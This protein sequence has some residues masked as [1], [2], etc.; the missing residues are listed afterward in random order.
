MVRRSG[1]R[2]EDGGTEIRYENLAGILAGILE[3]QSPKGQESVH[4]PTLRSLKTN[5]G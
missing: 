3:V 1:N 4:D 5:R 2:E